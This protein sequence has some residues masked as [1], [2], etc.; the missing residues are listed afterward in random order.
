MRVTISVSMA[1]IAMG[2]CLIS[3][4]SSGRLP[5]AQGASPSMRPATTASAPATAPGGTGTVSGKVVDAAANPVEGAE[6]S[7]YVIGAD[8]KINTLAKARSGKDG[9]FK[10]ADV[11]PGK[12]YRVWVSFQVRAGPMLMGEVRDQ[13]VEAGKDTDV[14]TVQIA[15]ATM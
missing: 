14:G 7:V 10:I 9:A 1:A 5:A 11:P 6:A 2:A 8:R 3:A 15:P 13:K 4:L 12:D